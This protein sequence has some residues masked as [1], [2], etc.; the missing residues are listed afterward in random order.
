MNGTFWEAVLQT[1]Q[2]WELPVQGR[3]WSQGDG[4]HF[5]HEHRGLL[6]VNMRTAL[7]T[8]AEKWKQW[9]V[10]PPTILLRHHHM[11]GTILRGLGNLSSPTPTYCCLQVYNVWELCNILP[12]FSQ[13]H[14]KI[15]QEA[16][17]ESSC[18]SICM[19]PSQLAGW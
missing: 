2:Q 3:P 5:P 8:D 18:S 12:M 15:I 9:P 17:R 14:C 11:S 4:K 13:R 7:P 19:F 6:E 1:P 16:P 10:A